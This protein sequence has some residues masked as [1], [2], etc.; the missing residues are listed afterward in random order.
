MQSQNTLQGWNESKKRQS[1]ELSVILRI[2]P[3]VYHRHKHFLRL[4]FCVSKWLLW[5]PH[6]KKQCTSC[7]FLYYF[8]IFVTLRIC[9]FFFAKSLI[10]VLLINNKKLWG[11]HA[12]FWIKQDIRC[13]F[14]TQASSRIA[15]F[16]ILE[17]FFMIL[18]IMTPQ[19]YLK[20]IYYNTMEDIQHSSWSKGVRC[21]G[22]QHQTHFCQILWVW[23]KLDT[24]QIYKHCEPTVA[25][26]HW[27]LV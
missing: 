13:Y 10:K 14:G 9:S 21:H 8:F 25:K 24:N 27:I 19:K 26:V 17:V 4:P 6:H 1:K 2:F 16:L 3:C 15:L 7:Y 5:L 18:V 20:A 22:N 11:P 12:R 23:D